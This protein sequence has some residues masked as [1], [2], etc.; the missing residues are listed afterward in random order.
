MT[1]AISPRSRKVRVLATL[2]PAS[3]TPEM[4]AKLFEAGADAFR[5]NMSHGD[6][7]SKV[8]VIEA[9]RGLEKQFGRP[10]TILADL[11]GPKLR[12]GRFAE[13]RVML[14]AG[15]R[16]TLDRSNEPG[17]ATRVELPHPEIFAAIARDARLLLDDGKLVLRVLDHDD[18]KIETEVVVGGALS[19][20][21]GL[22][23][24]D[25][26]LP[27]AA[28]TPKDISDLHFAVDQGVDWI[29]LSFVQ[30]P[31]DLAEARKLIQGKAALLAKIEK[32]SAVARLEEIVE[33]CD[34]VMVARGDLG[35]ELPP[36]SVPPLQKR[37]VETARRLGRPV[38]VATQMLESMIT[39]PSP[40][41][42]EVSDVATA[43]YDGAD[44]IMLSA[45]SAAGSWPVESVAMM[46]DISHAV[47]RDPAHG[48]RVHF[49]VLRPD[50]TTADALAEAAKNIAA[51]VDAKAIL[52]FTKSGSTARRIA[53]ERPAVPIMVLTPQIDTARRLGL[54]WGV[55]AVHTRDVESFEEMVAKAKRMVLRHNM[56]RAGDRV[57]VCAGVP[58]G[59]P[60]STNV[61]HV[62]Q[63]VGDELKNY[64]GHEA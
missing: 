18:D 51:T 62:V 48:D 39:S 38:V 16:F 1:K 57:V 31:E 20:S 2:G 58:F 23:V 32:P 8:A 30:R 13:G 26:V 52:C 50:P 33:Q 25:V 11:Q 6:Q 40:T 41:R 21:K 22:N 7:Q 54:L 47:E 35:V 5:V 28:L 64:R 15:Q 36:Q 29:A 19:N 43:V 42:A 24:P 27:M 9:I 37:I 4:I 44:A 55:H 34:G 60:G 10:T 61:L 45:E 63:I 46:N 3:N 59:T 56:A 17:D 53:R 12:V 14:E 49:T